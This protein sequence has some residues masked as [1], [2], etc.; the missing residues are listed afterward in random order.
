MSYVQGMRTGL[1]MREKG[2]VTMKL[3]RMNKEQLYLF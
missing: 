1:N 3:N 2:I